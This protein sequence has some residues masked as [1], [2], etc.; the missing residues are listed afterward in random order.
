MKIF[1]MFS[2]I[3]GFEMSMNKEDY[4]IIGA[5]EIDKYSRSV[6]EKRFP[7]VKIWED[8]RSINTREIPD[9]D[10]LVAG[11]PCQPFSLA[12]KR[13]GIQDARGTLFFEIFRVLREKRPCY[14]LLENVPGILSIEGGETMRQILKI[15][16]EL[17]YDTFIRV[18]NSEN[19]VPQTRKRV[20][21]IGYI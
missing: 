8:A 13:K 12:G 2:G 3:G 6:Y 4:T 17:H 19:F 14:I 7:G 9:H 10:M 16:Y 5:C 15:L 11:F 21:I 1:S 20:F 18:F